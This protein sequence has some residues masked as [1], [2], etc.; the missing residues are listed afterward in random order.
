MAARLYLT[1]ELASDNEQG[2]ILASE[3]IQSETPSTVWLTFFTTSLHLRID[4]IVKFDND[5]LFS[6]LTVIP[7]YADDVVEN[8]H[9]TRIPSYKRPSFRRLN[10]P[11]GRLQLF[12]YIRSAYEIK[13]SE[14]FSLS[15][16]ERKN[17]TTTGEI[18]L[19][20]I[21]NI[22]YCT[23][24]ACGRLTRTGVGLTHLCHRS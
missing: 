16:I 14:V 6:S 5:T 24:R 19:I 4:L 17:V 22:K 7:T 15:A 1:Y 11:P 12:I 2:G 13:H 9:R 18:L 20:T 10:L 8:E 21:T 3:V 23:A